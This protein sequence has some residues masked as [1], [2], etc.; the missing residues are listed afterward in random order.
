MNNILSLLS[1][2]QV[3]SLLS[4]Y[5]FAATSFNQVAI[6]I[7]DALDYIVVEDVIL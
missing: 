4:V 3:D 6:F 5:D 7:T 2:E 1:T